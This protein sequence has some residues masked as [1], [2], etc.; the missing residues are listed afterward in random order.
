M[1]KKIGFIEIIKEKNFRKLFFSGMISRFGDAVD[2]IAYAYMVY[3]LT[4]SAALMAILFAVNGIPSL[5][6]NM[7]SGVMV[8]Y[9]PKKRVVYLMDFMRGLIVSFTAILF[10]TNNLEVWHL[11]VL[12]ILNSTCEAFRAPAGSTLFMMLIEDSKLEAASSLNNSIRTFAEL[13]GYSVAAVLIGVIGVGGAILIDAITFF[14]SGII[15]LSIKMKKEILKKQKL[16]LKVYGEDLK[17]GL[18]YVWNNPLIRSLTFFAGGLMFFFSPFNA[19]ETPFVLDVME[20]GPKGISVMSIS[21]MVAM[22][23]GSLT[24]PFLSKKVGYRIMF[25][26]GGVIIGI[27]YVLFGMIDVFKGSMIGYVALA[28]VSIIMGSSISL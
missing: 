12:T 18:Q 17:E 10:L 20:L 24:V 7:I 28:I 14:V 4:G 2:A 9:M 13:I 23:L 6:F 5:V 1:D 11:Y 19:L 25:V 8:S 16:T 26:G 3:V 21:F 22:M 15:V 27:G